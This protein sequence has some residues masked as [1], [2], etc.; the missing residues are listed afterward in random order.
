MILIFESNE[1]IVFEGKKILDK[2]KKKF[3]KR[4]RKEEMSQI[5]K[6]LT[7]GGGGAYTYHNFFGFGA[8][9]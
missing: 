4:K 6:I 7:R 5:L 3:K 9:P 2:P 1:I 8:T